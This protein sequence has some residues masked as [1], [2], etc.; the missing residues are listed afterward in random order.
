VTDL[1]G[2]FVMPPELVQFL[3]SRAG[4]KRS[5]KV[6]EF[7]VLWGIVADALDHEP[8]KED[9]MEYWDESRANYYRRLLL[10]HGVWPDDETP[11]RVWEWFLANRDAPATGTATA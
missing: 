5:F 2:R 8:T 6:L 11:Q 1:F 9:F 4:I 3:T 7:L 10:W